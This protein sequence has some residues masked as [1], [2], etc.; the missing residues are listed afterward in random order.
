MKPHNDNHTDTG[1][2]E[3]SKEELLRLLANP[4]RRYLLHLLNQSTHPFELQTLARKIAAWEADISPETVAAEHIEHV[5]MS[6]YHK[7][8]P[9]LVTAGLL[10]FDEQSEDG[11]VR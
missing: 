4:R 6:L 7:Q 5:R 1:A 8:I 11:L 10:L 9:K 3:L 2:I